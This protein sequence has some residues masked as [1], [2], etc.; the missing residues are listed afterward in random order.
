M[1]PYIYCPPTFTI[2]ASPAAAPNRLT[3][4]LL[5]GLLMAAS[6]GS[7]ADAL[8]DYLALATGSFDS[9]AQAAR[10][11]RYDHVVWHTSEIWTDRSDSGI[12]WT[13]SENWLQGDDKPYRQR[14]SSHSIAADGSIVVTGYSMPD[15]ES[16]TGAWQD[17]GR[18]D[19]L[20][21]ADLGESLDCT[22]WLART[23]SRRFE[24]GTAGQG[25]ASSFR[26]ADYLISR[27]LVDE[28]GKQ[29]WD[30]GFTR[31][32]EQVW[33]PEAGPYR[34]ARRDA[35]PC[36]K[37]V[38]MLVHGEIF[39][40]AAFG[41]YVAALAQSGLYPDHQGYYLALTPAVDR[42]EGE[43]PAGRGIVLARF[44]CLRA[45]RNMWDSPTYQEIKALRQ[46]AARFEVMVLEEMAVPEY[47]N[48]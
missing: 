7:G 23:G 30:R 46:D 25:C 48:W 21:P 10:D 11:A 16:Y 12:R 26:G 32:G 40:R 28:N 42:F 1:T 14:I 3:T 15:A 29:N 43:P 44:P 2:P 27:S 5:A 22:P 36:S 37:P 45:A 24:G 20:S 35:D 18:L 8:D 39:D 19:E 38:L 4:T 47:I 17:T 13:Y 6:T 31:S 34:L 33:G 41:G 9:S